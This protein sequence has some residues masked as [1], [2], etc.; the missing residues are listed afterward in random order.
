MNDH[1]RDQMFGA[2]ALV[3]IGILAFV[4]FVA[5]RLGE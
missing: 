4:I 3:I 2:F 5:A 1:D